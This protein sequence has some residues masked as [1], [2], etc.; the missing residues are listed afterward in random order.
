MATSTGSSSA[1]A[2]AT[3]S[4]SSAAATAA[5]QSGPRGGGFVPMMVT[6]G[7]GAPDRKEERDT[8][9]NVRE[10]NIVAAKGVAD[11]IRTSLG[12]KGMDKMISA[13]NGDTVITND[14]ATILQQLHLLHPTARMMAELGKAQDIEAGDGTTSVVV[15]A[16]SM[17]GHVSTLMGKNIHPSVIARGFLKG[18]AKAQEVLRG[19]AIPIELADR[20]TLLKS[21]VTS[22]NSKLVSQY[23][24]LLAPIAV[25][26][27]LKV[28]DK[29]ATN[30]NMHD[31]RITKKVGGTIDDTELVDGLV[32]S[33]KIAHNAGGPTRVANAKIGL[34]QFCLSAPKT[35]MDNK[36]S[37][38]DYTQ[39]DAII[40][41]E[42]V[43]ILNLCKRI[44]KTGCNVLLVQKSILRDALSDLAL[45]YLAKYHI[46]VVHDIER[47]DIEFICKTV[48][49]QPI[50]SIEGFSPEKLGRAELVEE[51]AISED[52]KI[53]KVTGV[54]PTVKTVSIL[55]RGANR[56]IVDEA[57]RSL[58][59]ALCVVRSLVRVKFLCPG[60]GA[61][62]M[63]VSLQLR[64][65][66][67]TLTGVESYCV[68]AFGEAF[69]VIPYTL[70]ENAGLNPVQV[71]TELRN[72]HIS[73]NKNAGINMRKATHTQGK[74]SDM[75]EKKV[76]GPL[77][78]FSSAT[79]LA[80]ETV[81][82]ILKIDGILNSR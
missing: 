7:G 77:L 41:Q 68:R 72:A 1:A 56:L 36:V 64:E 59:D 14:G 65:Y 12:P 45:H 81:V 32:F 31:I 69:E 38:A 76:V 66:A 3:T 27:I 2:T 29:T 6:P 71:V 34:M 42:R 51:V 75:L 20:D 74:I 54:A 17:L 8:E 79:Q 62:E 50:A 57:E 35:N 25:N 5:P 82:M 24:S 80:T 28:V 47:D 10:A 67:K 16:G 52:S 23:S 78:V 15:L 43:Y 48:G 26:A 53:V 44:A 49:C 70:A 13:P 39:M 18:C 61:P 30:V 55:V 58:H 4:S 19:M 60:G 63:E 9:R 46:L 11:T 21:A 37:V 73:G 33:Q 22:L 40:A